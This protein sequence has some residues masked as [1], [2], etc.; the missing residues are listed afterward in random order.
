MGTYVKQHWNPA[1]GGGISRREKRGGDFEA[2]VPAF[3]SDRTSETPQQLP[4]H[5][6]PKNISPAIARR[7]ALVE[8]EIIALSR[9]EGATHLESISRLLLRS[10]AV[11]SSKIE[12]V[13]PRV[14]KV[15]LAELAATEEVRGFK[16]N[17]EEVARNVQVLGLVEQNFS[18]P[19]DITIEHIEQLNTHLLG[20]NPRIPTRLRT[21]QNWIGGANRTPIDADFIPP[22]PEYVPALMADLCEYINGAEHGALIQAAIVHAQFETIHP[23]ADGNGRVGRALIHGVLQRRGLVDQALLPISLILATWSDQYVA[24]LGGFRE[25]RLNDWLEIFITAAAEAV[26]QAKRLAEDLAAIQ[27]DWRTAVDQE[28]KRQGKQ[29]ALRADSLAL[30]LLEAFPAHPVVTVA[31]LT[32]I[33]DARPTNAREALSLLEAAGVVRTKVIG[34]KGLTGYFAD[35]VLDLITLADLRLASSRFDTRLSP[36]AGRGVPELP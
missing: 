17:A 10:E 9:I 4:S 34:A 20:P 35:D 1:D 22:P 19:E 26:T 8:R 3:L 15:A 24:G 33:Y 13:T 12:G 29:R 31:S 36:P 21:V 28:R 25:G 7:A 32:R 11:A 5:A 30:R 27:E 2:F 14:D 23:F 16:Q 18:Q 6:V